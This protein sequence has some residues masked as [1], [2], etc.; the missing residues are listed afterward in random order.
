LANLSGGSGGS[1]SLYSLLNYSLVDKGDLEEE[2][3]KN[4]NFEEKK[5]N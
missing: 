4:L 5:K 2:K 3:N 1:D